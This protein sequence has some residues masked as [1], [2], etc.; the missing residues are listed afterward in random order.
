MA[1]AVVTDSASD[2]PVDL[3][4]ELG[5]SVIPCNV[6]FG[7]EDF[8]DRVDLDSDE[9]YDRLID[10]DVFPKTSQPSPGDFVDLY[11][12]V[13][14]DADGIVSVH[15][16][17]KLSGTYNS[18]IQAKEMAEVDC[19]IEV[20]DS[21][22]ACMG[23]GVVAVAAARVA[24]A[25]GGISEVTVAAKNAVGRAQLVF[26]LATLEYLEKGG[27]IGKA[28][29]FLGGILRIKPLIKVTDGE[30]H[31]LSRARSMTQ[32]MNKLTGEAEAYA[33]LEEACVIYTTT[34]DEAEEFAESIGSL[35][36]EGATPLVTRAGPT[37]GTYAGPGAL[38]IGFLQAKK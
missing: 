2:L 24:A 35:M 31:G 33:P 16:S 25:G 12:S 26:L 17:S 14:K 23:Q 21:Y 13:A 18:A 10:G 30:V 34:P 28:S 1:I 7:V 8:K 29:A 37:I 22:Q 3:A 27:R 6:H 38:G 4:N 32:A 19:Q 20:V 11:Q 36:V 5:I 9:F 15:V